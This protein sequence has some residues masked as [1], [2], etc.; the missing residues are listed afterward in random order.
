[1]ARVSEAIT[2]MRKAQN[3][4]EM[5]KRDLADVVEQE[6][7]IELKGKGRWHKDSGECYLLTSTTMPT[8]AEDLIN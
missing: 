2:N 7:L 6:K 3:K 1:M 5:E 8:Q 4:R